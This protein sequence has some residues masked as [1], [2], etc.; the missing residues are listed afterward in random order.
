M[1]P[2]GTLIVVG[3]GIQG[4]AQTTLAAKTAIERADSVLFAVADVQTVQWIRA[5]SPA[6]QSLQYPLDGKPRRQIY[7]EMVNRILEDVRKGSK[8]CAVFYG[9]PGVLAEAPFAAVRAAREEGHT[10]K[11]LPGVSF[12]DCLFCDLGIDPG[13]E[14]CQ[15][16]EA[17]VFLRRRPSIDAGVP[18]VL[19]Q[20]GAIG[21][22]RT[23]DP[24]E[25]GRVRGGLVELREALREHY[26][27]EHEVIV[28]EASSDPW[29]ES[30]L[31]PVRVEHLPD[32][33]VSDRSTL[34]VPARPMKH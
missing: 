4:G 12:L 15:V 25:Q 19:C 3:T 13:R 22:R 18:L 27:D 16:F 32:A 10:A 23:F 9:H 11:M 21:N 14:G 8:V 7:H 1:Q 6:A 31:A 20:I 28:Y 24:N 29:E 30:R 34:V 5:L 17:G 26:P 33:A 2:H